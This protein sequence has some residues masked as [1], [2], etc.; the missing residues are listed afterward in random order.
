MTML[1]DGRIAEIA[2]T[3]HDAGGASL[4]PF[5]GSE[6]IGTADAYRVTAAL[7]SLRRADGAR[8]VGRG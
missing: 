2:R 7:A 6:E 8:S 1:S 3:V 5:T 4:A